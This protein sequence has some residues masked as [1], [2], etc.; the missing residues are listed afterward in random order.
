[1]QPKTDA[2]EYRQLMIDKLRKNN[3]EEFRSLFFE[4]HPY[5]QAKFF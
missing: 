2:P 3:V 5:D 4:L 1:M